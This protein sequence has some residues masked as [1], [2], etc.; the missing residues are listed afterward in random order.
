M[1]TYLILTAIVVVIFIT[2]N[3]IKLKSKEESKSIMDV[4]DEDPKY[5]EM[6]SLFKL[7]STLNE[8]GTEQ[9]T[10]PEGYGEFGHDATN[11]IPV[12]TIYGN[13][14]YLA[15]LRTMDGIKVQYDRLGSTSAANIENPIDM[16]A[17][18]VNEK[19]I[20]TL[21]I[22]PYNKKNSER[23]PKGFKLETFHYET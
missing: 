16:Y 10:I 13:T 18:S 2:M 9:D 6:K 11:P 1:I 7:M 21:Y 8:S 19:Q 23:A 5:Q 4:L 20:A 17:I 15:G 3:S 14:A 22:S 12:N